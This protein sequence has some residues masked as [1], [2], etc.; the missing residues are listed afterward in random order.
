MHLQVLANSALKWLGI[1]EHVFHFCSIERTL[2]DRNYTGYEL[3]VDEK[4]APKNAKDFPRTS[5]RWAKALLM[6][7]VEK[8]R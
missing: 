8:V 1:A 7:T 6:I 3:K 2:E 4:Y 5:L